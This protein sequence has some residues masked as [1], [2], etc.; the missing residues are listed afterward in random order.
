MVEDGPCISRGRSASRKQGG[1]GE[2]KRNEAT[3][4][5]V[6]RDGHLMVGETSEPKRR[7]HGKRSI[8]VTTAVKARSSFFYANP[9]TQSNYFD[10]SRP[11]VGL[12]DG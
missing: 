6:S 9:N 3:I 2:D 5:D 12:A 10:D 4:P 8:E 11:A 1:R 7:G